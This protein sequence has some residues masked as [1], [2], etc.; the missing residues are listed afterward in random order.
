MWTLISPSVYV[1]LMNLASPVAEPK[2]RSS[3]TRPC[4]VG[5]RYTEEDGEEQQRQKTEKAGE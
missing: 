4:V 3:F 2:A 1:F 5:G